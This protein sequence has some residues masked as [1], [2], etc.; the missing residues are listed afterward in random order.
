[1]FVL[2]V[3]VVEVAYGIWRTAQSGDPSI[4]FFIAGGAMIAAGGCLLFLFLRGLRG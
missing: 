4:H 1:V 2:V 3:G